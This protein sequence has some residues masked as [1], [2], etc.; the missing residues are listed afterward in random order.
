MVAE[1]LGKYGKIDILVN[2]AGIIDSKPIPDM[3]LED[4]DRVIDV[5]LKGTFLCSKIVIREMIKNHCGRIVNIS[6][7][8]GQ[9]GGLKVS[10]DYAS[11][12]SRYYMPG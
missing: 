11:Y 2:N 12:K 6:S 10:P 3:S 9:V 8:A 7:M 5:N 1:V 4:W